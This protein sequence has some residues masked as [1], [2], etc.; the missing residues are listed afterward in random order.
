MNSTELRVEMVRCGKSVEEVAKEL[1]VSG[2]TLYRKMDGKSDFY[3]SE[4]K[5]IKKILKLSFEDMTRIFF[6][7]ELN[8]TQVGETRKE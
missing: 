7:E 4:L 5:S 3:L 2:P 1:G 6:S 8:K